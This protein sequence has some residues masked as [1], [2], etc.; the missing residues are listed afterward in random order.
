MASINSYA[1]R[2]FVDEIIEIE[3]DAVIIYAGHNEYLGIMGIGSNFASYGGHISNLAFNAL[4]DFRLFQLFQSL[5]IPSVSE[6]ENIQHG[7]A[8]RTVM[9]TVAREK[10]IALDSDLYRLGIA[11]FQSNL[12]AVLASFQ[13]QNIP[14]FIGNLVSNEKAQS[15]FESLDAKNGLEK[16]AALNFE[17]A[18]NKLAQGDY[19]TALTQFKRARDLDL[20]RFR[21]PTQF[22]DVILAL[23]EQY[24]A[25]FVDIEA[26]FRADTATGILGK[27]H[28]L[29]HLHPT[30][31]GYFL[32]AKSFADALQNNALLPSPEGIIL[33]RSEQRM[34]DLNPLNEVDHA[35]AEIKISQLTADYP[36]VKTSKEYKIPKPTNQLQQLAIDRINGQSWLEQ[37]QTLLS[38]FQ[39]RGEFEKAAQVASVL[40]DA[41]P[42]NEQAAIAAAQLYL[43]SNELRMAHYHAKNATTLS[44][45]NTRY[46][47]TFAEVLFKRGLINESREQLESVLS[48][49]PNN[50]NA[51][52][53]LA[54]MN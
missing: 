31:R 30:A 1:L 47:L 13:S 37:Q 34:W 8:G 54:L 6:E 15:P 43:Q 51:K 38:L 49:E 29:E 12:S 11:Q 39:Q 53:Y 41:L 20:L 24:Q 3:P 33:D 52:R 50:Q 48:L 25:T 16:S 14:V 44:P 35:F 18:Q 32:M 9:A 19:S 36:F 40:S 10:N 7:E 46:K 26:D 2:D 27:K 17:Q 22:N 45:N 23:S 28:M 4:R 21:A 42:N 5:F